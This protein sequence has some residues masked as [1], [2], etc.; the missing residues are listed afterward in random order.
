MTVALFLRYVTTAFGAIKTLA[1][2]LVIFWYIPPFVRYVKKNIVEPERPQ[3][4]SW[5]IRIA[6][7]INKATD[8]HT[9][10]M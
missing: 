9:Q 1:L 4:S 7:W 8:T 5:P 6:C 3:M 10:N 2:H